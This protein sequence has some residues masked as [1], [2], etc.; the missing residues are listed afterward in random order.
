VWQCQDA[1]EQRISALISVHWDG[2][3]A[4]SFALEEI[5]ERKASKTRDKKLD[6]P[7]EPA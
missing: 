7:S 6:A 5:D 1:T 2:K 3:T 4:S